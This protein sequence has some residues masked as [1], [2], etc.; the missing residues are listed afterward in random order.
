MVDQVVDIPPQMKP[1]RSLPTGLEGVGVGAEAYRKVNA[2]EIE[3][4]RAEISTFFGDRRLR[5]DTGET[6]QADLVVCATGWNQSVDF[7]GP[8]LRPL[9]RDADGFFTLYRH[10]LPP[11][12]Q[13]LGFVGYASSI[14]ATLTSE[15]A[16]NWLAAFLRGRFDVP[17]VTTMEAE[18][19]RVRLWAERMLP[20]PSN[21][22]FIGPYIVDY[23]DQLLRDM[24]L[25]PHQANNPIEEY[26]GRF[27]PER[28]REAWYG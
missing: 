19:E 10:I 3:A 6:L 16:A 23:V 18:I 4:K 15:A 1:D 20:G 12:E 8:E 28:F 25:D 27:H 21:G 13:H 24:N 9:V 5:L 14:G 7:L 11:R 17:D 26:L 2:G 22:Y